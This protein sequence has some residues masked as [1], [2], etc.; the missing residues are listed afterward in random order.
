VNRFDE[1]LKS[2]LQNLSADIATDPDD[3]PLVHQ[4]A[5]VAR[6]RRRRAVAVGTVLV[7]I[8][9]MGAVALLGQRT[10]QEEPVGPLPSTPD[11]S[12]GLLR[13]VTNPFTVVRRI[14]ASTIGVREPLKVAVAPNGDVYVTDRGDHV[15]QLS[16]SGD[17]V[18]QWGGLGTAP[19]KF[20]L[21]SG[22]VAI[23][24]E[25]RVY[26]AD[27][28]NFRIQVFT[29]TGQF[30][31]QFGGYGQG[32]AEFVWP[33]DIVVA[34]DGTMY[35]ADDRAATVTALS[36]T[37][38]QLWR[39]GTRTETDP[40]LVGHEHLGG[41]DAGGL[42]VTANDD[43]GDVLFLGPDGD[44]VD[45]FNTDAAGADVDSS[46]IPGGH[47]PRGACGATL[48]PRGDVFVASCE[49]SYDPRH[50]TAVYDPQHRLIAGWM[51]G[52]LADSPVFGA[53][54][55]AWAVQAGRPTLLE[56]AVELPEK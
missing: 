25:G 22:A 14:D 50:D 9:L 54:S 15:T 46:G 53:D 4:L 43:A 41:I 48:D 26:V 37:G 52:V 8:V 1:Q 45:A 49:E 30:V 7:A 6:G 17:V 51:R 13:E 10:G 36:S 21:Y 18:R 56:L 40:E 29:A 42:L 24:P 35:V 38:E 23:G 47:F 32:P 27:T 55:H 44:V 16:P 28:G 12:P 5:V 19:G 34:D 20:R 39:R 3:L 2:S 33:S 11:P 31:T